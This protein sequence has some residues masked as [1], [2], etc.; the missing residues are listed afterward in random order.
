[1]QQPTTPIARHLEPAS[2]ASRS[3][4][5]PSDIEASPSPVPRCFCGNAIHS[6]GIYCSIGTLN[7][8]SH[9][10]DNAACARG[11]AFS[12]LCFKEASTSHS[13]N[14]SSSSLNRPPSPLSSHN[15]FVSSISSRTGSS[16]R[17]SS[18]SDCP[19][20][21]E[22][23]ADW[24]ASHYRRLAREELRREERRAERRRRRADAAPSSSSSSSR[25]PDLIGGNGYHS[26]NSSVATTSSISTYSSRGTSFISES[27]LS[28]NPSTASNSKRLGPGISLGGFEGIQE[29][30]DE[31]EWLDSNAQ[32]IH[33]PSRRSEARKRSNS[34]SKPKP[35]VA[36]DP[37]PFG[38]GKDMRDVLDDILR[39][40]QGFV[41]E[42]SQPGEGTDLPFVKS[43][44]GR[45]PRTP[46]PVA[47]VTGARTKRAAA[48]EPPP[49]PLRATHRSQRSQPIEL[50][51]P[52]FPLAN[53]PTRLGHQTSLSESHTQLLQ[54]SASPSNS[55]MRSAS[56]ARRS[57][58]FTPTSAYPAFLA[59]PQ[60]QKPVAT[61]SPTLT[62]TPPRRYRRPVNPTPPSP[63]MH[64]P[65]MGHWRFPASASQAS[66]TAVDAAGSSAATPTRR[67][68]A[69]PTK[70]VKLSQMES[71]NQCPT[72]LLWPPPNLQPS[73][74]PQSPAG[75]TPE[76]GRF[77]RP[78]SATTTAVE[79][80]RRGARGHKQGFSTSHL[81]PP[82]S[83]LRLGV[84][85]GSGNG[86]G[87]GSDEDVDMDADQDEI[88]EGMEGIGRAMGML[89]VY[90]ED[91]SVD[92]W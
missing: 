9:L 28:R 77:G 52:S 21:P 55:Q 80:D 11:D 4:T 76:V 18:V 30:D 49:A 20:D 89:P 6:D 88:N 71:H 60:Y 87:S 90:M 54:L 74:F 3:L 19:S 62:V 5:P 33:V 92:T 53:E 17:D 45:M 78:R 44:A 25:V 73:L 82:R 32:T 13:R 84:L 47:G 83:G 56:P 72:A 39:M 61:A 14:V 68:I 48:F 85:C 2:F 64:H 91:E 24:N 10:A 75:D 31:Q 42:D 35:K 50:S 36:L 70:T 27:S 23:A 22:S 67:D 38:M 63:T 34:K 65:A 58:T 26:R 29:D 12:S 37:A 81:S 15:S 1:M 8:I 66:F 7:S 69:T 40:E 51:S 59:A 41:V 43:F 79:V 46:S 86:S 16:Y 57:L